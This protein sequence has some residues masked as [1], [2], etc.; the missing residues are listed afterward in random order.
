MIS[1]PLC[2][3]QKKQKPIHYKWFGMQSLQHDYTRYFGSVLYF[4]QV[5][6]TDLGLNN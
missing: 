5:N 6:G 1:L 4:C 3:L 2:I